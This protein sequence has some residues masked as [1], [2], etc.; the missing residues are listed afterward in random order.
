MS[1]YAAEDLAKDWEFKIVR[2]N[3]PA[4]RNPRALS[5]LIEG[6]AQA[7]WTMV[8]KFDDQRVR[9]KRLRQA[10]LEDG[11]L[12]AGIDP[13]RTTYGMSQVS[14]ALV[15]AL[16]A[17]SVAGGMIALIAFLVH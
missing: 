16:I 1:N 9:F 15:T 3:T 2:A 8:E 10:R 5:R 4:F 11:Q 12:P 14:F 17:L 6:E 7:G 13:Y